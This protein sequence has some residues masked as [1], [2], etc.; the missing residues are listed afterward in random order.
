M[1]ASSFPSSVFG[2]SILSEVGRSASTG[3]YV[4]A[5]SNGQLFAIK[6]VV[7]RTDDDDRIVDELQNEFDISRHFRHPVLRK[8]LE[9]K[10]AKKFLSSKVSEM[11]LI[12]EWVDGRTLAEVDPGVQQTVAIFAQCVGAINSMHRLKIVHG[13][14]N[15]GNILLTSDGQVKLIDFGFSCRT[16]TQRSTRMF[17]MPEFI[18]PDQCKSLPFDESADIYGVGASMYWRLTGKRV[19]S[20]WNA[21][22]HKR[23]MIKMQTYPSPADLDPSIPLPLSK[24]VM[25]CVRFN[26]MLRF[27]NLPELLAALDA[28]VSPSP[29]ATE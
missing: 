16:L 5:D 23:E 3:V 8:V 12:M 11:A 25:K 29:A 24:L 15:P 1:S 28:L 7:R 10:S 19:P 2:Y 6:H 14:V 27:Q 17:R 4:G 21:D 22:K 13:D 20:Y 18:A 9:I 26:P